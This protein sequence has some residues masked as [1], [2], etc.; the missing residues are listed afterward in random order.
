MS[1]GS[2]FAIVLNWNAYQDT[3]D[4]LDSLVEISYDD[5]RIVVVDNG[6]KDG[7]GN[8]IEEEYP[9]TEVIYNQSN[10]G[11]TGGMNT[12]IEFALENKA[13][14]IWVLNNDITFSNQPEIV[15]SLTQPLELNEDIKMSSP[16][17][18]E[19]GTDNILFLNGEISM[20]TGN[21][22][23]S[24]QFLSLSELNIQ[25]QQLSTEH[26]PLA[27]AMI[28]ASLFNEIGILDDRYFLY[29]EDVD[30][31][32]RAKLSGH[33]LITIPTVIIEHKVSRSAGNNLD[34]LYSY[35]ATRNRILLF[36]KV[37]EIPLSTFLI[38]YSYWILLLLGNRIVNR[39]IKS[40]QALAQ[41]IID[42]GM[43]R[44]GRGPYP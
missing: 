42:G 5:L 29:F 34:P 2:V 12:G 11:F 26:I 6:S 8:K 25:N 14:Y 23:H 44:S 28:D 41:G 36:R 20:L 21:V 13:D 40:I 27:C 3:S 7:S 33:K 39:R 4:C 19:S 15:N 30:F 16:L 9:S 18:L 31:S 43:N 38:G 1:V 22:T 37:R 24:D 35:Y 10:L 17:I 32:I